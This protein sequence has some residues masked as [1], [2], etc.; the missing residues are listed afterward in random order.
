MFR[1]GART[2]V[3]KLPDGEGAPVD[4]LGEVL[5]A[6]PKHAVDIQVLVLFTL[7]NTY[8]GRRWCWQ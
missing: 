5:K 4:W 6:P 7:H 2:P 3:F 1:H 8:G